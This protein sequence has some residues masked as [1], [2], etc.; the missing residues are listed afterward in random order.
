MALFAPIVAP[1][2]RSVDPVKVAAFLKE[3][4]RYE[5]EILAKQAE[6]PSLKPAPYT[7]SSI[8]RC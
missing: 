8:G 2:L 1:L 3:S 4:E 6:V 7:G 5:M